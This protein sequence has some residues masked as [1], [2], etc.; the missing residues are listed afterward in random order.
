MFESQITDSGVIAAMR[1]VA[2]GTRS[3]RSLMRTIAGT[4]ESET[5]QNFA[6]QG[7]PAWLGLAPR[8][9]A[10]RGA[11]ARIL[12]DKGRLAA[13]IATAYGTDFVQI[14]SNLAYAAIHQLGGDIEKAEQSRL[15]RHRTDAK[16]NLLRTEHFKGR[17]LVFAKDSHKRVLERWF[18]QGAHRVHIPAR[19]YLPVLPDGSLQPSAGAAVE[20]DVQDWLRGLVAGSEG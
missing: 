10:R 5:E 19:P 12:Q 3:P 8:T 7:R 18:H 4:L 14:G 2:E 6:A 13:S 1:R 17:G 11:D 15:V 20:T 16:G 9:K